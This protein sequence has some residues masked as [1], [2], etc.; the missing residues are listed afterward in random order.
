MAMA[1]E[2]G[3]IRG[4]QLEYTCGVHEGAKIADVQLIFIVGHR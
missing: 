1:G 2:K 4:T 3:A